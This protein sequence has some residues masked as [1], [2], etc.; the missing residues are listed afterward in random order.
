[1]AITYFNWDEIRIRSRGDPAA[2]ILLTFA[3]TKEYNKKK[4]W[5]SQEL[6]RSLNINHI[7]LHLITNGCIITSHNKM[8]I[9]YRTRDPQG[10]FRNPNFLYFSIS[11]YQKALY[12]R[13]LSYRK[14]TDKSNKI[15]RYY[16]GNIKPHPLLTY[17]EDYIYFKHE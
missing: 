15:P 9:K 11:A 14:L 7:P 6:F 4:D 3:Q 1:M 10:Y 5:W 16:F 2:I 8:Q 17:D 12:L 13:A